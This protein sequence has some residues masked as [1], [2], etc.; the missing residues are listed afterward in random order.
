[1]QTPRMPQTLLRVPK[2]WYSLRVP[3]RTANLPWFKKRLVLL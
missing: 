2:R 1:V 3:S